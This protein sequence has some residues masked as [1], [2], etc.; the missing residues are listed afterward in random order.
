MRRAIMPSLDV[1]ALDVTAPLAVDDDVRH[2]FAKVLRLRDGDAVEVLDGAG[3]G[4]R[5]TWSSTEGG[6]LQAE[7]FTFASP[8]PPLII[9]QAMTRSTKLEEVVRRGTELGAAA[10]WLFFA[11]RTQGRHELKPKDRARLERVAV[12]AARQSGRG[13]LPALVG[14]MSFAGLLQKLTGHEA[15]AFAGVVGTAPMSAAVNGTLPRVQNDGAVVV[16]GPEGGLSTDEI[17]ALTAQGVQGVGLGAHVMRTETAGPA[18]L[19]VLQAALG[20]M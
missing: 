10:F 12:D 6:V 3:Q 18:A 11:D 20:T 17:D 13:T 9:A 14:P 5:G 8:L 19:A 1:G 7:A 16:V 15:P 2:Y 4:V